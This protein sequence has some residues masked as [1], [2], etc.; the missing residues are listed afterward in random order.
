LNP[1][2]SII[3]PTYNHLK[4]LRGCI[5]SIKKQTFLDYEVWI[6]DGDSTDGTKDFLQTLQAPFFWKSEKDTGIYNAM[7]KGVSFAKGDWLYFLGADDQ[8]VKPSTLQEIFD[9][10]IPK[11][12]MLLFGKVI[13]DPKKNRIKSPSWNFSMWIRNGVHHQGTFYKKELFIHHS[14]DE[15]YQILADYNL[16]LQLY[17]ERKKYF[18]IDTTVA[19]CSKEGISSQIKWKMY[20]EEQQLKTAKTAFI[21]APVFQL[22][23]ICKYLIKK[24]TLLIK[25]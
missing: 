13:I 15:T 3:I 7:N 2:V 21:L 11:N 14:Y 9:L 16:N 18:L 25:F 6:I 22:L 23:I 20:Q 1:K 8:L 5:D 10:N 19:I 17:Q 12:T 24:T 4:N